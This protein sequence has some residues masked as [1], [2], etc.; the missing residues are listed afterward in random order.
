MNPLSL[1]IV[2]EFVQCDVGFLN[3][4]DT[5]TSLLKRCLKRCTG[6]SL[7]K[8]DSYLFEP[9]GITV[10]AIIG[11]SHIALHTYPEENHVSLDIFT[12]SLESSDSEILLSLLK[13]ELKPQYIKQLMMMRGKQIDFQ[14]KSTITNFS[15]SSFSIRYDIDEYLLSTRSQYQKIDIISHKDF[16]RMLFLDYELQISESDIGLYTRSLLQPFSTSSSPGKVAILGGGDGSILNQLLKYQPEQV[17]LVEI[18]Q[19]IIEASKQ[20]LQP[21]C[22][23]AFKDKRVQIEIDD[24]THFLENNGHF[25]HIIYDLTLYPLSSAEENNQLLLERIFYLI[26]K[27]LSP[28][29]QLMLQ[30]CSAYDKP[31]KQLLEQLLSK[32]FEVHELQET[33]LPSF[34]QP[35]VFGFASGP[36]SL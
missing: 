18:D 7:Q 33:F 22:Q 1:H 6:F 13:D 25:D 24:V 28:D 14:E 20:Y 17:F 12:C 21:F 4:L 32:Y 34:C 19:E 31:R 29:G 10:F 3:H 27:A 9:I 16:G 23:Q 5:L 36:E 35:W 2:A 11:E 26:A 8:I 30:G 15:N